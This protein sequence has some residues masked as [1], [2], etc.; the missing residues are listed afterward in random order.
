[1][2]KNRFWYWIIS[3]I[4]CFFGLLYTILFPS[5]Y[6]LFYYILITIIIIPNF[7]MRRNERNLLM[8]IMGS[9]AIDCNAKTYLDNLTKYYNECYFNSK[10]KRYHNIILAMINMDLGDFDKAKELLLSL[11]DYVD[12][13]PS[14][15]KYTYYRAWTTYYYEFGE[16]KHYK[17]LLDEMKNIVDNASGNLK[18]QLLSNYNLVE[19]KYF[20]CE[21]IYLDKAK[22]IYEEILTMNTAPILRLSAHYYLGVI[23]FK[24]NNLDKAMDEFK[25]VALSEKNLKIV[26]K[27]NKYLDIINEKML[28]N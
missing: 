8:S 15:Q 24:T 7:R 5:K 6:D 19:A 4:V 12:K 22:N 25:Y 16:T 18:I 14:F 1:M 3:I 23:N 28:N 13:F 11:Q 26:E 17:I 20:I 9:Y 10:N 21:G 2:K 27:S